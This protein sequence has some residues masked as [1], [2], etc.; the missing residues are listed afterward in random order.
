MTI[1]SKYSSRKTLEGN[2]KEWKTATGVFAV[3]H[4]HFGLSEA[5][6]LPQRDLYSPM[7]YLPELRLVMGFLSLSPR[8]VNGVAGSFE[9]NTMDSLVWRD[10]FL[11]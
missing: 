8:F 1:K 4:R 7:V 5:G 11:R 6:L 9:I 10:N 2:L 3:N